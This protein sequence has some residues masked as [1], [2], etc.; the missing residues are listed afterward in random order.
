MAV[1][2][3]FKPKLS[4]LQVSQFKKLYD[5]QP[6]KFNDQ[7]LEA[8]QQHAEYYRLP[9]AES[10]N[11]FM[12]KVGSVF[13]QAGQ[14]FF[15]GFTTFRTGDP[16]KDDAEAISRNIGH[17]AGFVGYVP[18]MPFKLMGAKRLAE[19]AKA[20]KGRSVPMWVAG[21]AEKG[22]KKIINPIYGRAI[23]ARAA[24][25]KTATGFLQNNKVHDLASGAFHLGVASAV[26]SWQGG[27]DEMMDSLKHG[28]VAGAAFRGIGNLVQTGSPKAD[29]VLKTLSGSLFTGLPSTL[30]GETTPMQIYQYLLGAYFGKN[31]MPVHRRMGQK[32]LAKMIK[33][34][35][36]DPEL[37][38]GWDKID[39]PGQD[40]VV[41]QIERIE[42][43]K[44]AL[45]AEIL[46]NTKGITPEEA[47]IRAEE[48][49]KKQKELESITFTEEGEP[50]RDLTKEEIKEMEDSGNDVDPQIV[51]A[52]LSINAKSFV[53]NNMSAYMEGKSTG[54]KLVVASDLNTKWLDLIQK[55]RKTKKNPA[56]DMLD[57]IT[58]KHPE[59][60][61]LKED[62]AFWQGLGFMRIKQRPVNMLTIN[63]GR[64]RVMRT[65]NTGS[66][67]NDAGNRKQLSQEPKLIEEIFLQDYNKKFNLKEKEP[68]GVYALLDHI[69]RGTPT[70]QREFELSK[71]ADYLAQREAVKNGR[72]FPNREDLQVEQQKYNK[73]IGNLM[74]F[75]NSKKNNMYYYGG[76]GDAS[77]LYFVKYHPETPVGKA[78][79][80]KAMTKIK[81][82]MRK[83][84]TSAEQLKEIDKSRQEF[85]KKYSSGIGNA[86]RAGEIFDKAFVSNA[87]YDARLNGYRGL[88]DIGKVLGKGYIN[89]AKAFNK[90]SQ[91]WLTS[92]YSSDPEALI[93]ASQKARKGKS[94]IVDNNLNIKL[95]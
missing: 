86:D 48:I 50:L 60:S 77:R 37:V 93:L 27:V 34:D 68:R 28:A 35:I 17:L 59:F 94:Y 62:K 78:N 66:A 69:V 7:T 20:L 84:N 64:P 92:G 32:H 42:A 13:K 79:V 75:M 30:R 91:I 25:G 24:A 44:N 46:K 31:E 88:E 6:D 80:K 73:E 18:S 26:S 67:M 14:G 4:P 36:K 2:Q 11:S 55:G 87:I 57:Y 29:T 16:P 19:A 95:L 51:P 56:Q 3:G 61:P 39:K 45:A 41:K 83:N 70:G 52:R 38:K 49:L 53:D 74:G 71:Y 40:W 63:N 33:K 81:A 54:D 90:R 23:E 43:P 9:F 65:D 22:A 72:N 82:E 85:I 89:D 76:R 8:L 12:G 5:Q 1:P 10:N 15:E 21:K 58:E 47:E